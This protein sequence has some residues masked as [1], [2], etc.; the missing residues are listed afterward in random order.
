MSECASPWRA[1]ALLRKER[2]GPLRERACGGEE[3][4]MS[5]PD[6]FVVGAAR[7]PIGA[8]QGAL[9][10]V[11]ATQLGAA[12]LRGALTR[13]KLR[14]ELV[15]AAFMGNV[16]SAGLG[17]APARQAVL[18][19]GLPESVPA[20]TVG[21]VCGSGLEAILLGV[22]SLLLGDTAV[23][24]AGGMESMSNAPY[25]LSKA[26]G[27]YRMG[28]GELIDA[29]IRDGLWDPYEDF[30]MGAAAERS[31]S[32]LS[33]TRAQQDDFARASYQRARAAQRDGA[34]N[35]EI[36]PV[37]LIAAGRTQLVER[38]EEPD[39]VDLEKMDALAPVF[40]PGGT[41]TA[42]NASK[43][44]DGAAAVV[45]TT[46]EV[47]RREGLTPLARV[48]AYAGHAQG[49]SDFATAPVHA[50]HKALARASLQLRDIDLFEINEA[51]AAVTLICMRQL[52]LTSEQVNVR[53]GAVA[54]GHP[55]GASGARIVTTLLHALS[56]RKLARGVATVCLGGG[57]AL[58][59]VLERV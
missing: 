24:L 35:A 54:L 53:G 47:V 14:G 31:A 23:V 2:V 7:T 58:A 27:G 3:R 11:S 19:A 46:G 29:L 39:R 21:K 30:H 17:Q 15:D 55:I 5:R 12:A 25:L 16:L 1:S 6:V 52:G 40:V 26:R 56:D 50:T 42:A 20:T 8:F 32:E 33:V 41:I 10:R 59:I 38:D 45:L 22:R 9:S 51:F 34:F 43:I 49:R 4:E 28:H 18:Y 37:S 57:E 44:S 36:E 13:S 48:L